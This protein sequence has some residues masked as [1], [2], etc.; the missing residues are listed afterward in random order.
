MNKSRSPWLVPFAGRNPSGTYRQNFLWQFD[1]VYI[2]DNHRAALWCWLQE[3]M[4][5]EVVGLVH[6]DEHT[7]TLYSRI[8]EW[9]EA[10]P[11]LE[12]MTIND[13]LETSYVAEPSG[14]IPIIRWDNYLS[15]FLERYANR[16]GYF[17]SATYGRGDRP[18]REKLR[19]MRPQILPFAVKA[20]IMSHHSRAIV[21]V[22]M[23]YFFCDQPESR[24]RMLSDE[25]IASLFTGIAD[26]R[27]AG[28]IACLTIALSPDEDLTGGWLEAERACAI[29]CT[30]LG[31]EFSLP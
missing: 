22:D 28:K 3:M 16:V 15:I 11:C 30:S 5:D 13:Y 2:M 24:G 14:S 23:D 26:C 19:E 18:R 9:L 17:C 10:L 20:E 21:N 7:D 29:A 31:I 1:N 25:Y 27:K 6:I 8:D 12:G 4:K